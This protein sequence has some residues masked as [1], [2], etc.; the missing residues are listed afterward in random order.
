MRFTYQTGAQPLAGYTIQR[1]IHR[2]GFG[3]VYFAHSDGGKEVALKL[4]HHQDQDVEIRGVTQCLNL[5]HP[6]LVNLF[7]LKTDVQGDHWVVMEYVAGSSLEDVL[8][9]FPNGLPLDEVRDWL[10]G[11]VAGVSH[12]HDRGIVHRDLKPGNVYRENGVVKVGDVGLSKRLDSDRRGQHTQSVGTVYYM[13]PEVARG[14]YGPEVDVYSLGVMLYELITGKLPFTGE[15]TAEILMKHLTA[16]PDLMPIPSS[17]RSTISRALEKDPRKRTATAKE[18]ERDFLWA[19]EGSAE[20]LVIP[21]TSFLPQIPTGTHKQSR[22][23]NA[24]WN[25]VPV[26]RRLQKLVSSDPQADFGSTASKSDNSNIVTAVIML[27]FGLSGIGGLFGVVIAAYA[28]V[29]LINYS[30]KLMSLVRNSSAWRSFGTMKSLPP[31]LPAYQDPFSIP[32]PTRWEDQINGERRTPASAPQSKPTSVPTAT[33]RTKSSIKASIPVLPFRQR[34]P[35]L[36]NSLGTASIITSILSV[37]IYLAAALAIS[38]GLFRSV[39]L[40][41]TPIHAAF[42]AA[43]SVVGAWLLLTIHAGTLGTYWTNRQRWIVRMAAGAV[44]GSFAYGLGKF[45]MVEIPL[46]SFVGDPPFTSLGEHPLAG[47]NGDPTWLG[48]AWFFAGW[49][50]MRRWSRDLDQHRQQRFRIGNVIGAVGAAFFMS[51]LFQFPQAYGL[52]WAGTI[53]TAVQLASNWTPRS[54]TSE[55]K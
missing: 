24:P 21:E 22:V 5:K 7:D 44:I 14:Q 28:F 52:V 16:Q 8:S 9:S 4:L 42:F 25:G 34:L 32:S 33:R 55:G 3:E 46:I 49:L 43:T 12:L 23:G 30:G 41:P 31:T 29:V 6:N 18:L 40:F 2:G 20:P 54:P 1:G 19:T 10:C 15:T 13:A 36:A 48:Y 35:E 39:P 27:L 17:L 51:L 53:S 45:L 38:L 50:W 37:T 26:G 11:L 47:Q